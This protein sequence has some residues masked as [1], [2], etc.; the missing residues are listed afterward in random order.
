MHDL[1]GIYIY[2]QDR[3]LILAINSWA[4]GHNTRPHA[5]S[6]PSFLVMD[7]WMILQMDGAWIRKLRGSLVCLAHFFDKL[8]MFFYNRALVDVR[9]TGTE[10][11]CLYCIYI[12]IYLYNIYII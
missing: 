6:P 4:T 5:R 12:C 11:K 3:H 8:S 7:A 9:T 2:I 1:N 10:I